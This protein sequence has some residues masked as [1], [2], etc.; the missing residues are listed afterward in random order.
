MNGS[1]VV[2]LVFGVCLCTITVTTFQLQHKINS[3]WTPK[4]LSSSSSSLPDILV[5]EIPKLT[6]DKFDLD[7]LH[8]ARPETLH[9]SLASRLVCSL[10]QFVLALERQT[11]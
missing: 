6:R 7:Q 2:P 4:V 8:A 11:Q 3:Y 10:L 1:R 9:Y 5:K